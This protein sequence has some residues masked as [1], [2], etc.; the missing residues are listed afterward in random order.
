MTRFR[1]IHAA[2]LHLDTPFE[3]IGRVAPSVA[4]AL[5]EASLEAF[6]GLVRLAVERHVSFV[7][8]AGDIY[9]G[10]ERGVR[11]QLRFLRGLEQLAAHGIR[12]F[13]VYG[14]HD[15]LEG[16]SALRHWPPEVITF[17]ADEVQY[18]TVDTAGTRLATVYG[19]S[20]ARRATA[21]NLALRFRRTPDPGLHIGLLHCNVGGHPDHAPYSP[22]TVDDL[23][24]AGMHYWALGHVHRRQV[25]ASED[26]WVVYPGN[27]QGRSAHAGDQGEKGAY[28]VEAD[29]MGVRS[30]D[31]VPLDRVR[32]VAADLDVSDI[33]DLAGLQTALADLSAATRQAQE[34]RSLVVRVTLV[35]RGPVHADAQRVGALDD[36]LREM[37][38]GTEDDTPFFWWD[39]LVDRTRAPLDLPAIRERGDLSSELMARADALAA[40]P[41]DL[42]PILAAQDDVLR[43]AGV[44]RWIRD[45][46]S[47]DHET[48]LRDAEA[49]ALDVLERER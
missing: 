42:A 9:D 24:R 31:F 4:A 1:F 6:D 27:L 40:N 10:P 16:W 43:R 15:P 37:R 47:P 41:A 7:L 35:G 3:G 30:V 36:L 22:C 18:A 23:R 2:D 45:D 44:L 25:L 17:G 29:E 28:L 21:E 39:G 20:Y 5:R 33:E 48:L 26:P 19:I 8:L 12:T 32:F 13:I 11:A 14:N 38:L 46:P 34:G 49:I